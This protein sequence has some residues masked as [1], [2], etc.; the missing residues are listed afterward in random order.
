MQSKLNQELKE[1]GNAVICMCC[2]QVETKQIF[3]FHHSG[4]Q[5]IHENLQLSSSFLKKS[6]VFLIKGSRF[7]GILSEDVCLIVSNLTS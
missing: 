4:I 3:S 5:R 6:Q 1:S 7:G 2:I